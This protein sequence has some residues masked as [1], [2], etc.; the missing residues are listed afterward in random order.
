MSSEDRIAEI[1]DGKYQLVGVVGSGG[2][3]EVYQGICL[4]TGDKVAVKLLHA[5]LLADEKILKRFQRESETTAAIIHPNII[6]LR[7][8]GKAPWGEPYMV[9]EYLEG[10]SLELM[11]GRLRTIPVAAAVGILS[12]VLSALAQVHEQGVIHRDLKPDNIFI[13]RPPDGPPVVKIIDF[14]ISHTLPTDTAHLTRLTADGALLGTPAYMSP[15]QA[16]G[17][18]EISAASD[19]FSVGCIFYEMLAGALPFRGDNYNALIL[20]ILTEPPKPPLAVNPHFPPEAVPIVLRALEKEPAERYASAQ[21]FLAALSQMSA[22]EERDAGLAQLGDSIEVLTTATGSLGTPTFAPVLASQVTHDAPTVMLPGPAHAAP[23]GLRG[24]LRVAALGL[25]LLLL[26]AG[27]YMWRRAPWRVDTEAKPTAADVSDH[28]RVML[29]NLPDAARFY[30][31]DSAVA[32]NP[33]HLHKGSVLVQLRV[34]A[35]D[36]RPYQLSFTPDA[37]RDIVVEMQKVPKKVSL[38]KTLTPG[39]IAQDY[40]KYRSQVQACYVAL[41]T[42]QEITGILALEILPDGLVREATVIGDVPPALARCI[43][44]KATGWLFAKSLSGA[45]HRISLHFRPGASR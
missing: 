14:G 32:D 28:V 13:T 18:G 39:L 40:Q 30:I 16:R 17:K 34:E 15:E 26:L 2:M 11:L 20:S 31:D 45:S 44:K 37:D 22:W 1:L 6:E 25:L 24:P 38:Y 21:A 4:Q 7:D 9:M 36:H 29:H 19:L 8:V 35:P 33:F 3:G 5:A 42:E 23:L 41:N 43:R 10:E 12:Q 27:G